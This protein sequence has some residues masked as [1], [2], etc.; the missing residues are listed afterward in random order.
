[1][2][3]TSRLT[4]PSKWLKFLK[5]ILLPLIII[6][7]AYDL[8]C[9]TNELFFLGINNLPNTLTP[10]ISVFGNTIAHL[11]SSFWFV[12]FYFSLICTRLFFA[13]DSFIGLIRYKERGV[14]SWHGYLIASILQSIFFMISAY[15][16]AQ[17]NVVYLQ[18]VIINYFYI[19]GKNLSYVELLTNVVLVIMTLNTICYLLYF[20]FNFIYFKKRRALFVDT[21]VEG[22]QQ[23]IKVEKKKRFCENCGAELS[24]ADT[25]FCTHCGHPVAK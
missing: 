21:Y 2:Q 9:L 16:V 19:S 8:V 11:G 14:L 3:Y 6:S 10:I 20:I 13:I 7:V 18:R 1:M 15:M 12:V 5:Y 22:N 23:P 17:S 25:N 24:E 4:A